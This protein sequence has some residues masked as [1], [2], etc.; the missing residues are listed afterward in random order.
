MVVWSAMLVTMPYAMVRRKHDAL[1][2]FLVLFGMLSLD[3]MLMLERV[4]P[5]NFILV[6]VAT[7][8]K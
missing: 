6:Q 2:S 7:F 4:N 1:V 5:D 8:G 3:V